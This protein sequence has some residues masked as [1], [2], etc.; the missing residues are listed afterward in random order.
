[1]GYLEFL[2]DE[3][4]RRVHVASL[5]VLEESGV[6]FMLEDALRILDDAGCVVDYKKQVAKIPSHL[7]EECLKKA[8]HQFTRY[9][10]DPKYKIEYAHGKRSYFS[11]KCG[12]TQFYD[13][14]TGEYRQCTSQDLASMVRLCD[15]LPNVDCAGSYISPPSDVPIE[16]NDLYQNLI[17]WRNTVKP[18]FVGWADNVAA[19]KDY[20]RML[21][22]VTGRKEE[23]LGKYPVLPGGSTTANHPFM[24]GVEP[25]HKL[26]IGSRLGLCVQVSV[27]GILGMDI[28][29]NLGAALVVSNAEALSGYVLAKLVNPLSPVSVMG[30]IRSF[31]MRDMNIGFGD[32]E[33]AVAHAC[34]VQMMRHYGIPET[35]HAVQDS[36]TEDAQAGY[37]KML[38]LGIPALAGASIVQGLGE[39]AAQNMYSLGQLV[40]DNEIVDLI[41][42]TQMR[43]YNGIGLGEEELGVDLIKKVGPR[44]SYVKEPHTMRHYRQ[45]LWFPPLGDRKPLQTWI[46]AGKPGYRDKA[47]KMARQLLAKHEV[48]PLPKDVDTELVAIIKEAEKREVGKQ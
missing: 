12:P 24:W 38:L 23:E 2:S 29:V 32:S 21:C 34:Q 18:L 45:E 39:L 11:L 33:A 14:Q 19:F 28:P 17:T 46:A 40:I 41:K 10:R 43:L 42:R 7:V 13:D 44:G 1:M 5:E 8:I 6:V 47:F 48:E 35:N 36:N 20:I 37:G 30:T 9:G 3:D 26:L 16:V 15:A 25:L 22:V 27:G 4:M 31:D